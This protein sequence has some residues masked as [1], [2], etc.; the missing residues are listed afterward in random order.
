MAR[1]EIIVVV[2]LLLPTPT[3]A[4]TRTNCPKS[5]G[6]ACNVALQ[7]TQKLFSC[8][9]YQ[10]NPRS[11]HCLNAFFDGFRRKIFEVRY[12]L[13]T[14]SNS[15]NRPCEVCTRTHKFGTVLACTRV[16]RVGTTFR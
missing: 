9:V 11:E 13:A 7:T 15:K 16:Q 10:P 3:R 2:V 14:P 6:R 5:L 8:S 12:K 1:T 4:K